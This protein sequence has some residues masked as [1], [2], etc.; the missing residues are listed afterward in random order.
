MQLTFKFSVKLKCS[1]TRMSRYYSIFLSKSQS[2]TNASQKWTPPPSSVYHWYA[3]KLNNSSLTRVR[4]PINRELSVNWSNAHYAR[5]KS[6]IAR[7]ATLICPPSKVAWLRQ[8]RAW[9]YSSTRPSTR[10]AS[11]MM[12]FA[13]WFVYS[14]AGKRQRQLWCRQR[15]H[16]FQV[17]LQMSSNC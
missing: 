4:F 10:R 9:L 14:P 3:I 2:K 12:T 15:R 8:R 5:F 6:S 7:Q 16:L 11:F 13:H 17:A 1:R